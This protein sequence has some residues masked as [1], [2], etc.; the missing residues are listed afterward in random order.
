M[1]NLYESEDFNIISVYRQNSTSNPVD[2]IDFCFITKVQRLPLSQ[3]PNETDVVINPADDRDFNFNC[4]KEEFIANV[5]DL[6]RSKIA[7]YDSSFD[8]TAADPVET[9][10][11]T[12]MFS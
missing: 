5:P 6:I 7:S 10:N 3:Y 4:T 2:G 12:L 1:T 8:G 11:L 9:A